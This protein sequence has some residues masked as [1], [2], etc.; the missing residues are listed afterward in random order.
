MWNINVSNSVFWYYTPTEI[1]KGKRFITLFTVEVGPT[2]PFNTY[3]KPFFSSPFSSSIFC[4]T[5]ILVLVF[6]SVRRNILSVLF[7]SSHNLTV[8]AR[9]TRVNDRFFLPFT[10]RVRPDVQLSNV[11]GSAWSWNDDRKQFYLHQFNVKQPDFN[12]RNEEV[13]KEML[14]S[15]RCPPISANLHSLLPLPS[16]PLTPSSP[17]LSSVCLFNRK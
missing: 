11:G 4:P 6:H 5:M 16:R 10:H 15:I 12:Y 17:T 3:C 8:T 13:H 14:V 9:N 1:S 2:Y 7:T